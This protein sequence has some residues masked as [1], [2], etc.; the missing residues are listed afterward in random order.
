MS[1][2]SR[3]PTV[4]PPKLP[5]TKPRSHTTANTVSPS[6]SSSKLQHSISVDVASID[7]E[8]TQSP[9]KPLPARPRD[10]PLPTKPKPTT[11]TNNSPPNSRKLEHNS[12]A[13]DMKLGSPPPPP[14]PRKTN[15]QSVLRTVPN[16][17]SLLEEATITPLGNIIVTFN[18]Y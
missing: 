9:I 11:S 7:T 6:H 12:S 4:A 1:A 18:I 8:P 16:D 13:S 3:P 17:Y 2:H 10:R 5:P 15:S 14:P